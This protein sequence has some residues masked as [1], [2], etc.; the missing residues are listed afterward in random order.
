MFLKSRRNFLK[1]CLS[2]VWCFSPLLSFFSIGSKDKLKPILSCSKENNGV[3]G[4]NANIS[5]DFK[6]NYL[7]L[8]KSGELKRRGEKLWK[9]MESCQICPRMC[10][11]NKLKGEKGFC[12]ADSQLE[13]ASYHAHYGEEE[14]LVGTGGSGTIFLSNCGLRCVFCI[15]WEISQGGDGSPQGI[16]NFANMMLSLQKR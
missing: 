8:H 11:V 1:S 15:N 12:Q 10:G 9:M 4:S 2:S 16:E 5:P 6:P 14:P 3:K 7:K 13:I